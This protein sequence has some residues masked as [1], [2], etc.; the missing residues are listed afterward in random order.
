MRLTVKR[1]S[2]KLYMAALTA[3]S[4][5][6]IVVSIMSSK[7]G[8][9]S[10]H[11]N[12]ALKELA[13]TKSIEDVGRHE[14]TPISKSKLDKILSGLAMTALQR[15]NL[16][17]LTVE[18]EDVRIL[19]SDR[20]RAVAVGQ[21][22]NAKKVPAILSFGGKAYK[23]QIRLKGDGSD[24]WRYANKQMS[25]RVKLKKGGTIN[26]LNQFSLTQLSRRQFPYDQ[27]FEYIGRATNQITPNYEILSVVFNDEFWGVM[28][29]EEHM[30]KQLLE[31]QGRKDSPIIKIGD[32][33]A[34]KYNALN[35][36][37]E[38]KPDPKY[39]QKLSVK[40]YNASMYYDDP[41]FI[42]LYSYASQLHR[43]VLEHRTVPSDLYNEDSLFALLA[44]MLVW[45]N[46]HSFDAANSR[47][48]VNPYT[49]K[50]DV[51]STD[52]S[53]PNPMSLESLLATPWQSKYMMLVT[54]RDAEQKI[55]TEIDKIEEALFTVPAEYNR[56]CQNVHPAVEECGLEIVDDIQMRI[57]FI[58]QNLAEII[59]KKK[60]IFRL[61]GPGHFTKRQLLWTGDPLPIR[62][63]V[64]YPAHIYAQFFDN[65]I[66]RVHN[67][68]PHAVLLESAVLRTRNCKKCARHN[69]LINPITIKSSST[70]GYL[71]Y[72]RDIQLDV[73]IEN[74]SD[75]KII[76]TTRLGD[77]KKKFS[78]AI[79]RSSDIYNPLLGSA[80]FTEQIAELDF[81]SVSENRVLIK[82]GDWKISSPLV[83]PVGASLLVEEGTTLSFSPDAY[84]IVRGPVNL[85]G[86]S[87]A[88]IKFTVDAS[89]LS[90][91]L[92]KV[93]INVNMNRTFAEQQ[94]PA[95][96]PSHWK[97]L[98]V[99]E[100]KGQSR[101]SNVIFEN[102][103]FFRDGALR[104]TGG[105]N[106]Y[107]SPVILDE[108]QFHNSVAEDALNLVRSEFEFSNVSFKNTRSDAFDADYS[109]GIIDNA[110]FS[111]IGGDGLDASGS[112]VR[113][114][115]LSFTD[116][117][118]KSISAGEG[119][120][121]RIGTITIN[122]SGAGVVS[123]DSSTVYVKILKGAKSIQQ[124]AGMAYNKKSIFGGGK[125][126]VQQSNFGPEAFIAQRGSEVVLSGV[127]LPTDDLNVENLY[128]TTSGKK[129]N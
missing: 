72:Y 56:L 128:A 18:L 9:V 68:L 80:P 118:D 73:P 62:E 5:T 111:H 48:Y 3:V 13:K 90:R 75:K 76:L 87:A 107:K 35:S 51:I 121:I 8:I 46:F 12:L 93:N 119:S 25:L 69:L 84:M 50:L 109:D 32:E 71:A 116:V 125:L 1:K 28:A 21:L 34:W 83:L 65:G 20:Q 26:G 53:R 49:L 108:V 124:Y 22:I 92:H 16:L 78:I 106:F 44:R 110:V 55:K 7:A 122:N 64:R 120:D 123:K 33:I 14:L 104:L 36:G 114:D 94:D 39:R 127:R 30:S 66:L 77:I 19:D 63:G 70:K 37:I 115:Q 43:Q 60:R 96:S 98:Y 52:G 11:G 74:F 27:I 88:P 82:S 105:V 113:A 17:V 101:L 54:R 126:F 86:T 41:T 112:T 103:T 29:A 102:T 59:A 2:Q 40:L 89:P 45:N 24:H 67:Y 47:Y 97:G 117:V 57:D 100:A 95:T 129:N 4:I 6:A 58:R 31:K 61:Y 99:F 81:I 91:L 79:M 38:N 85:N 10:N 15:Q 42:K 23:A